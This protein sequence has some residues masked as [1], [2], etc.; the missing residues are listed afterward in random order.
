[1]SDPVKYTP[2]PAY[3]RAA[4][5]LDIAV[6]SFWFNTQAAPRAL[7]LEGRVKMTAKLLAKASGLSH[8]RALE[9]VAHA[10]RFAS[11]HHLSKH[12]SKA[13]QFTEDQ[14]LPE[15]WLDALS[16]A[17][18]LTVEAEDDVA[19]PTSVL[20]AFESFGLTL[21]ML[22]DVP[23]DRVLDGVS[24]ALCGSRTW[25]EVRQRSP[26]KTSEP[27]YHFY[28]PEGSD[29]QTLGGRFG[30][31]PACRQLDERLD[32]CWDGFDGFTKAQ[33]RQARRWVEA[34]LKAQPGFL[35]GGLALA[36]M[37]RDAKEPEALSTAAHYVRMAEEFIPKG[38]KGR[39][40]WGHLE[41][42][43]FHRLLWLH[44][45]LNHEHGHVAAAT[46]TARRL[47][48]LNPNDNLGVRYLLP[49]LLLQQGDS[50][51]AKRSLK[52]VAAESSR[53]PAVLRAFVHFAQGEVEAF[54]AQLARALFTLPI[55]RVF[56]LNNPKA[57]PAGDDGYRCVQPDMATFSEFAWPAYMTVP[58]L[59][60]ACLAFLADSEVRQCEHELRDYWG[61]Y[62][63]SR[64]QPGAVRYGSP[65][66]WANLVDACVL[67]VA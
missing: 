57:L 35:D 18:V 56:F 28:A 24:A 10:L 30:R 61:K 11:W 59:R 50:A 55:L 2:S 36:W 42:R 64:R 67:R 45:S 54:R 52:A 53:D 12:L 41:N 15:G 33:K 48:R 26:L 37:Q 1:M 40:L 14:P 27:L 58:G 47:L 66:G 9:A 63:P 46:K 34:T 13:S 44:M 39:I 20:D 65:D 8:S 5:D 19:L 7:W 29:A 31:S 6:E 51:G 60:E 23:A 4:R 16:A 49:L 32:E 21:S 3:D 25:S 43:M 62:W 17:A 22:T 38:F